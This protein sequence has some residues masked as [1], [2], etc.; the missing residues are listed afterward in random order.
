[1]IR[2]RLIGFGVGIGIGI[3]WDDGY[4]VHEESG[5]YPAGLKTIPIATPTSMGM[6][7]L[8]TANQALHQIQ[9]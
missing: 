4:T 2:S 1:M 3:E 7:S 8:K 5:E 6:G 9:P